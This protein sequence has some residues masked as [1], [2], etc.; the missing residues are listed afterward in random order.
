MT[1]KDKIYTTGKYT[2][3]P[4]ECTNCGLEKEIGTNHW[5]ECYPRCPN[6]DNMCFKC[7]EPVPKGYGVPEKWKTVKLGD[8]CEIVKGGLN[9]RTR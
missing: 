1:E 4:Y 6:C 5:G 3:K 7:N 2:Y 9:V 8:I